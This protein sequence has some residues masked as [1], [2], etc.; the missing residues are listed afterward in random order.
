[1]AQGVLW[2]RLAEGLRV[3]VLLQVL[4]HG[5]QPCLVAVVCAEALGQQALLPSRPTQPT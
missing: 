2:R 1:M 3:A 4:L 5:G